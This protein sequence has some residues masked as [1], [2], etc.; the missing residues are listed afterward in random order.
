MSGELQNRCTEVKDAECQ[1]ELTE[2]SF[3]CAEK[4]QDVGCQTIS[5]GDI[6]SLNLY[7]GNLSND[8]L[9]NAMCEPLNKEPY[10]YTTM[11]DIENY[12]ETFQSNIIQSCQTASCTVEVIS[13][14]TQLN[15]S[16]IPYVHVNQSHNA[17]SYRRT[18]CY[19]SVLRA[20]FLYILLFSFA[21]C[22]RN[23]VV[24]TSSFLYKM[25][26]RT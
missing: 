18:R 17:S 1:T 4:G 5:T 21:H 6:I 3:A 11:K 22:I 8:K 7:Y 20:A 12:V 24:S 19:T 9:G 26:F 10:N 15:E 25:L 23:A 14:E 16:D 2:E 13:K